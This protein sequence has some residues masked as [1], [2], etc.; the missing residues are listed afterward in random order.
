MKSWW[1]LYLF[2]YERVNMIYQSPLKVICLY[3]RL[4]VKNV[5]HPRICPFLLPSFAQMFPDWRSVGTFVYL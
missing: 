2:R 1:C 3:V 5:R 4:T